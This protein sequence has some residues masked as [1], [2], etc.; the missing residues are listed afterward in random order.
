M[1]KSIYME[2]GE[3]FKIALSSLAANKMR[4]ALT[5]LGIIIGVAAV[6]AMV[7][8]GS[9]AQKAIADRVQALGSN[10][11][12]IRPG[13]SRQGHIHFGSGS[14]ITLKEEDVAALKASGR[15]LSAVLPEYSRNAQAQFGNKNWNTSIVG[16]V[17][18]YGAVRNVKVTSGRFFTQDEMD[19]TERVAVIGTEVQKNLFGAASPVGQTIRIAQENFVVLGLLETKGQQGWMN[20]DDQILIPVTTAQRRVFGA[21][22]LTGITVKVLDETHVDAALIEVEKILR[23]QHRLNRDQDND[24]SIRNQSDIISTMQETNKTFGF[25]LAAIAGVSLVVGGIGIMNI[26]LVSVTERTREI[27]IRKAIGARRRDI[28]MQ[29]LVESVTLSLA[30]G[31]IG[32]ILGVLISYLLSALAHWNT[33]ISPASILLSFGFASAVGLFFGLYPARKASLLDP[34]I[35]LRY[36]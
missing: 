22:Y 10:L 34:I 15:Y 27:G 6:I 1:K 21:D 25:L 8:L 18:E 16:T 33:L 5:M 29:F 2:F 35:A 4:A 30:G 20:Q 28:M 24:F 12:F 32:I 14:M 23:R 26:M 3:S 7:G 13:S 31:T 36:E 19:N 11:L 9:G 17:P